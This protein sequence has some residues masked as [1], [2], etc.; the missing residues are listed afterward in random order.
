MKEVCIINPPYSFRQKKREEVE[1]IGVAYIA[2]YLE[3]NNIEADLLDCPYENIDIEEITDFLGENRYSVIGISSYYYNYLSVKR[4]VR[5]IRKM[6][7]DVFVFLGGYLPTL[8]PD[9]LLPE[10][11]YVDAMVV[12]EGEVTV[13]ELVRTVIRGGNWKKI[14]G[15]VY[16]NEGR[17]IVNKPRELVYDLD[18]FPFPKRVD[19]SRKVYTVITSRGCYGHCNFCGIK[20]FYQRNG[21]Y[22]TRKR[23]P[24]NVVE[25]IS[26]LE[27]S[28]RGISEIRFNDD[29][30][31]LSSFENQVWFEEFVT[32]VMK[33]KINK[34]YTCLLR[35]NDICKSKESLKIFK[36]IGLRMVFVGIESF[37]QSDLDFYNKHVKVIENIRALQICDEIN[38]RYQIGFMM[39]NPESTLETLLENIRQIEKIEFNRRHKYYMKP[40]SNSAVVVTEGSPI[41]RY[42]YEEGLKSKG[43]LGYKFRDEKVQRCYDLINEWYQCIDPISRFSELETRFEAEKNDKKLKVV[44]NIFFELF[45]YDLYVLKSIVTRM[46]DSKDDFDSLYDFNADMKKVEKITGILKKMG[47]ENGLE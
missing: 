17:L 35:A 43:G 23:T 34:S 2:A 3:K 47:E 10:E 15:I 4:I 13:C 30:F 45:C 18:M 5:A 12:G 24:Q 33:Y 21:R 19:N 14:R 27:K 31:A 8:S 37:V 22:R 40:I 29:N 9:R 11:K 25:E 6:K 32:L 36:R 46:L 7:N 41:E 26:C 42:V 39:F 38:I 44:R 16:Y 28:C 1:H 20:E